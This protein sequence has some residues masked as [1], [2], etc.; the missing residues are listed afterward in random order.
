MRVPPRKYPK[1]IDEY[2][3]LGLEADGRKAH[4]DLRR[5]IQVVMGMCA[6][7]KHLLTSEIYVW[8]LSCDHPFW[9]FR[10]PNT[11][12]IARRFIILAFN[13]GSSY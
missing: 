8:L 1:P 11:F 2:L 7:L 9:L 3:D 10:C 13:R 4:T 12:Q 6:N 5:F